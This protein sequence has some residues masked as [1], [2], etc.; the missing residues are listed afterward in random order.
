MVKVKY[1]G[2]E[3]FSD[4]E[5]GTGI[6][7]AGETREIDEWAAMNLLKSD[8]FAD[9]RHYKLRKPIVAEPPVAEKEA[10]HPLA[11]YD[12]DPFDGEAIAPPPHMG[13]MTK[14]A[15]AQWAKRTLGQDIPTSV[16]K[17]E[18]IGR[19]RGHLMGVRRYG[20]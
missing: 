1:V 4:G 18:M 12:Q 6:W 8:A 11:I 3:S 10:P 19:V 5:F 7:N 15:I 14:D 16:N 17:E 9:A 13:S 20:Y 2:S